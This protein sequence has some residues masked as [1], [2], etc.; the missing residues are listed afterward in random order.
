MCLVSNFQL[1]R[2][3]A[4]LALTIVAVISPAV[5]AGPDIHPGISPGKGQCWAEAGT[6]WRRQVE[7]CTRI[8]DKRKAMTEPALAEAYFNRGW[9]HVFLGAHDNAISDFSRA[10]TLLPELELSY[11]GRAEAYRR[12]GDFARAQQDLQELLRCKPDSHGAYADLAEVHLLMKRYALAIEDLGRAI[13]LAPDVAAFH[14][15]QADILLLAGDAR[16]AKSGYDSAIS[17][18][19]DVPGYYLGRAASSFQLQ[20]HASALADASRALALAPKHACALAQRGRAHLALGHFALAH[21]DLAQAAS[22]GCK[23]PWLED[24]VRHARKKSRPTNGS[25]KLRKQ[26]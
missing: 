13:A 8:I 17:H 24:A 6:D 5:A 21:A 20:D 15:R 19:A 12:K 16:A 14:A 2:R 25:P 10:I 3:L 1:S 4:L 23:L 11:R 7:A 22:A 9:A 26:I 18:E